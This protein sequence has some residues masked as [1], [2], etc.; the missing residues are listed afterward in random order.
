M[1]TLSQDIRYALRQLK[2]SPGF[3]LTA[4]IT[5]GLG[6]GINAAMF[7][8]IEQVILRPLPYPNAARMVAIDEHD[9]HSANSTS[10]SLPNLRDYQV[11]SHTLQALGYY[12]MQLPTL[13]GTENPQL[14]PQM[15]ISA[16]LLQVL[17]VHPATGRG[18]T[19]EDNTP[20]HSQILILSDSVWRKFYHADPAIIGRSVPI[21]GDPYTV[22]GVLPPDMSFPV[23]SKDEIM[24]PLNLGA[25]DL[26]D[27]NSGVL[28]S[29]GLLRPGVTPATAQQELNAIRTQLE[30]LYPDDNRAATISVVD[31]HSSVTEHSRGAIIALDWAVL[32]VWLIACAN[33]AGLMLTRMNR[34]RRE[35]AI[36]AALGAPR[37]RITQQFLTE[38][39]L[40]AVAGSGAG[41]GIAAIALRLLS[42]NL[43]DSLLY[44][45]D[46]HINAGVLGFLLAA[47]CLSA[48]AF[49]LA[50]AWHAS[51]VPAQEGLREASL[52]AGTSRRQ[53]FWRDGLVVCEITLTLA[54]L[55]AA[56]LM[57]RTLLSLRNADL[58][59]SPDNVVT[60]SL[61]VPTHGAWWTLNEKDARRKNLVQN[62]YDPLAEKLS[63]TP[64]VSAVGFSTVRPLLPAWSFDD[65]LK[66]RNRPSAPHGQ[67]VHAATRASTNGFFQ[68]MGIRLLAGRMFSDQ[69]TANSPIA[70]LVNQELVRQAFPGQNPIG[71]QIE[72]DEQ[73]KPR[74]WGTIVG[75]LDNARQNSPGEPAL[76]E[77]DLNLE[78]LG[79]SDG[80]YPILAAFHMDIAVRSDLR[81]GIVEDAI[82]RDVHALEPEVAI[83]GLQPMQQIID[84]SLQGQT[85]AARLL[86]IFGVCALLIAV[87][88]IYGLL[89]YSV[90]QRTR[91]LG[92]RIALGAEPSDIL[93]LVLRHALRLLAIGVAV[94]L[95]V[96]WAA[97]GLMRSYLYG[98]AGND[99]LTILVVVVLLGLCGLAASY[100]PAR[101]AA[102]VDP[103]EALRTE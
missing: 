45:G 16:S 63:H 103:V 30:R 33:V 36:R 80:F 5:L 102:S 71:Q 41:L 92:V 29:V 91:E 57:M 81:S 24:S 93:W 69:D 8:V 99:L 47:S 42:H 78:Q 90:S 12:T 64:G 59:F 3:A 7:S 4:I 31:Y 84:D 68:V 21:N 27:R 65:A 79:P 9:P 38:S 53:A 61:H 18:F 32:A 10:I 52:T 88:G 89:A 15:M 55:I 51:T 66:I 75:V 74:Q 14:V 20:G 70:I 101:R 96:A 37:G 76:P 43:T 28:Q 44:G 85:L 95:A 56:G 100:L 35:I 82:R 2:K 6:I 87:A 58:G 48:V 60:G 73:G 26:Q 25:K 86:G 49:G 17:G 13:G 40:L 98:A 50:P 23:G 46:I 22:V 19:T 1:G 11:R 97:R 34:R 83:E 39:L 77:I 54:L 72:V 62:F 67:E 94:G